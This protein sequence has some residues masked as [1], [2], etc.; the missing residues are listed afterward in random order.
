MSAFFNFLDSISCNMSRRIVA[1]LVAS[2]F[3][4][5]MQFFAA[6]LIL[7][8]DLPLLAIAAIRGVFTAIVVLVVVFALLR[9][10]C[11]QRTMAQDELARAEEI[12]HTVRNS[13]EVIIHSH[14]P[15][16]EEHSLAVLESARQIHAKLHE[17]FP[18]LDI[19]KFRPPRG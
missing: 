12:N 17:L 9:A 16:S 14:Y 19:A 7:R 13:L 10:I 18:S 3:F 6:L 11:I 15:P 4:G 2:L 5:I 1:A 8:S